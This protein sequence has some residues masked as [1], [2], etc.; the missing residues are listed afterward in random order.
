MSLLSLGVFFLKAEK[1]NT[2]GQVLSRIYMQI[3]ILVYSFRRFYF[4]VVVM[5]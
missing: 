2:G 5:G 1:Q 3:K 4:S